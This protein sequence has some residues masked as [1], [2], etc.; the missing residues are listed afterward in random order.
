MSSHRSCCSSISQLCDW[1]TDAPAFLAEPQR[2]RL[3]AAAVLQRE[4]QADRA[5]DY[6]FDAIA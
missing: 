4:S 6:C 3:L 5:A 1:T 2:G